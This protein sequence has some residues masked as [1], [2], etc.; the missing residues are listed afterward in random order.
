MTPQL[1]DG[2]IATQVPVAVIFFTYDFRVYSTVILLNV[3]SRKMFDP[4]NRYIEES[5]RFFV[6]DEDR[7]PYDGY[8]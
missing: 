7:F 3:L 2:L 4:F 8:S 1:F 5:S 6:E